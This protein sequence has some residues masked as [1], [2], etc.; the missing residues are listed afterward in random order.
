MEADFNR[1]VVKWVVLETPV[2]EENIVAAARIDSSTARVSYLCASPT[3]SIEDYQQLISSSSNGPSVG[4]KLNLYKYRLVLLVARLEAVARNMSRS[5]L[6]IEAPQWRIDLENILTGA[7]DNNGNSNGLGYEELSGNSWP[8][9]KQYQLSKPTM[10]FDYHK[11]LS[12]NSGQGFKASVSIDSLMN[13]DVSPLDSLVSMLTSLDSSCNVVSDKIPSDSEKLEIDV[14][15]LNNISIEGISTGDLGASD[16]NMPS[17][18]MSGL[19]ETLFRGLH[20]MYDNVNN[21][22]HNNEYVE[23]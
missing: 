17:A 12:N 5:V 1:S 20:E 16:S 3:I 10:V 2:P 14:I 15:D 9:D 18:E 13:N 6:V 11:Q 4:D 7:I 8:E 22:G 19:M 21:V 23:K